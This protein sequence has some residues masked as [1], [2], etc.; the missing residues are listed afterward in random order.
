MLGKNLKAF[1]VDS[2]DRCLRAFGWSCLLVSPI[3][4]NYLFIGAISIGDLSVGLAVLL[5]A[6]FVLVSKNSVVSFFVTAVVVW[7]AAL[8]F[9]LEDMLSLSY[10]RASI[11]LSVLFLFLF[12][13]PRAYIGSVKIYLSIVYFSAVA[14]LLQVLIY[15][16]FKLIISLQLPLGTYEVD[17]VLV[18]DPSIQGFR[19]GGIFKEPSYFALYALPAVMYLASTGRLLPYILVALA[20]ILSTS[21][22]GI[23]LVGVSGFLWFQ[24]S[25]Q[26]KLIKWP[27]ISFLFVVVVAMLYI[28]KD[29]DWIGRFVNIFVT[30]GTLNDRFVPLLKV[31]TSSGLGLPNME[32]NSKVLGSDGFTEWYSSLIYLVAIFG[33][34]VIIPLCL[35]FFRVGFFP[36]CMLLA[37]LATTHAF[38]T[39][40]FTVV[41]VMVY[42]LSSMQGSCLSGDGKKPRFY[43]I[44]GLI[45]TAIKN[46]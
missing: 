12:L 17:T 38:S 8:C 2:V 35:I 3:F 6:K 26:F 21:S 29:V 24:N 1:N 18:I 34:I 25:H 19:T 44:Y 15:H 41:A 9:I 13:K 22:L 39:S 43:R 4:T 42:V 36:T 30:G 33:W 16:A 45:R 46:G 40:S 37:V 20:L 10:V 27:A 5:L 7:V 28:F 14:L 32:M 23:M 31:A 11:Y